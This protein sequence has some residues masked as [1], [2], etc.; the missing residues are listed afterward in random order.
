MVKILYARV[1]SIGQNLD[2]QIQNAEQYD[3]VFEDKCSGKDTNRPALQEMLG[4]IREGDNVFCHEMSRLARN[5]FDLI[6]LVN[7]IL[8]KGASVH[9]IKENLNFYPDKSDPISQL[10]LGVLAA[11]S[12]FNRNL[13]NERQ[14]EGVLIAKLNG[15]YKG[16]KK[17]L[18]NAQIQELKELAQNKQ[19]WPV[20]KLMERYNISRASVYNYLKA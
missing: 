8:S 5:N 19:A 6:D 15:R 9:F 4:Y 17:H 7:K 18:T 12:Q 20:K 16:T 10:M 3:K 1:S 14:K 13:I 2:R 11:I